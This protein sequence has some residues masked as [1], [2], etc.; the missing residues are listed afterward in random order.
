MKRIV[1]IILALVFCLNLAA[2]AVEPEEPKI[3][4]SRV[5]R[6]DMFEYGNFIYTA[7]G[8][9]YRFNTLT[10]EVE[11]ACLDPECDGK[12]PLHGGM[13]QLGALVGGRLY[14]WS[15]M[16]FTHDIY[17]GYQ[18]LIT[19][20]VRVLVTLGDSEMSSSYTFVD[21]GYLYYYAALLREGGDESNPED[22][23]RRLCRVPVDGGEREVV[24]TP[25]GVIMLAADGKFILLSGTLSLYNAESGT[26]QVIWDYKADGYTGISDLS[27]SYLDGKIYCLAKIPAENAETVHSEYQDVTY[28][29]NH[30]L[31]SVDVNTGEVKRVVEEAVEAFAVT[32][33]RIYYAPFD[34]RYLFV[35][36]NYKPDSEGLVISFNSDTL[37]SCA[38][39]GSDVREEFTNPNIK[40]YREFTVV[41]GKVCGKITV[42]DENKKYNAP[43]EFVSVS[44]EDGAVLSRAEIK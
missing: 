32:D 36:E 41:G 27:L 12:C 25:R 33:D 37:Y 39:D 35:P 3:H 24:E 15:F 4:E 31:V 40:S 9:I 44:L 13:S 18:D 38:H 7:R 21:G 26:E 42:Y 2:C 17:I 8:S 29:K 11:P 22:Y 43:A 14:F 6:G 30:F 34:V 19:G 16:P 5:V 1:T 20:E 10:G 23:E 28:A